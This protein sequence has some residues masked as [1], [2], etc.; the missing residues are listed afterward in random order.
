VSAIGDKFQDWLDGGS[1]SADNL[2]PNDAK[3][4]ARG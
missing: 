2:N 4:V 1:N 3:K